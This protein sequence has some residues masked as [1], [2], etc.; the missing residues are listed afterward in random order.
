M[1]YP[2]LNH[3]FGGEC[4]MYGPVTLEI[5]G[6]MKF[7]RSARSPLLPGLPLGGPPTALPNFRSEKF[8]TE[9]IEENVQ[10]LIFSCDFRNTTGF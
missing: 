3:G 2:H 1:L 10:I 7:Y 4:G 5:D 6:E 9:K 8:W